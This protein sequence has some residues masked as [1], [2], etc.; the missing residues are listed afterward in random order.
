MMDGHT[1]KIIMVRSVLKKEFAGLPTDADLAT[2]QRHEAFI[3]NRIYK[4]LTA[5]NQIQAK[6]LSRRLSDQQAVAIVSDQN[7]HSG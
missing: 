1:T 5:L 4:G 3:S 2:V 6:R 7:K